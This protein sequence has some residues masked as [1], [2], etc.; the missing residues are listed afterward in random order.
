[1]KQSTL[2]MYMYLTLL[3]VPVRKISDSKGFVFIVL[4]AIVFDKYISCGP[5]KEIPMAKIRIF[6]S[7]TSLTSN[8]D[9]QA[10]KDTCNA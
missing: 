8:G 1:M 10:L 5:D 6:L 7:Q 2:Y 9:F 3:R 4:I